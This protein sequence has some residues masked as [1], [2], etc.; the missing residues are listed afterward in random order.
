MANVEIHDLLI[1]E[2]LSGAD[3]IAEQRQNGGVYLSRKVSLDAL[4]LFLNNTLDYT[5][6]LHTTDKTIIGAINELEEARLPE[7]PSTD[8]TYTLK[9]TVTAGVPALEWVSE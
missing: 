4:G 3:V 6:E 7:L 2:G 5:S 1:S 9:L 8:G